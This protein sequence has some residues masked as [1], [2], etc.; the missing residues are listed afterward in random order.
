MKRKLITLL[1]GFTVIMGMFVTPIFA[2][3]FNVSASTGSVN[4]GGTFTISLSNVAGEFNISVSNGS[5]SRNTGFIDTMGG[6]QSYNITAGSSGTVTVTVT[7]TA[8]GTY[9]P[10]AD[11]S[12]QSRSISVNIVAPQAPA[13]APSQPQQNRP[14]TQTPPAE[15]KPEEPVKSSDNTLKSISISDGKLAPEFK[16]DVFEYSVVLPKGSKSIKVDAATNDGKASVANTGSHD[17]KVG[18]N[19]VS[20]IVTPEDGSSEALYELNIYVEDELKD[21]ISNDDQEYFIVNH[22]NGVKLPDTFKEVE[23]DIKGK[24]VPALNSDIW[25][26]TLLYLE[27]PDKKRTFFIVEKNDLGEYEIIS[28]FRTI[29]INGEDFLL[30][31]IPKD[32][33][34]RVNMTYT[35]IEY[36]KDKFKG[37]KYNDKALKDYFLVYLRNKEGKDFFYQY[38][39]SEKSWQIHTDNIAMSETD[40][41]EL[42]DDISNKNKLMIGALVVMGAALIGFGIYFVSESKKKAR[43][44]SRRNEVIDE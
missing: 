6:A 14:Q 31:D 43:R 15:V 11:I 20:L 34:E 9:V 2:N 16:S 36:E 25:K 5:G 24:K 30:L 35:D 18:E 23:I 26:T 8:A 17:L 38:E 40:F 21:K 10:E 29:S 33:Q 4:P 37:F 32:K 12:G 44:R 42:M 28:T 39:A 1:L 7:A 27:G 22:F 3:G 41:N 19:V 13:P